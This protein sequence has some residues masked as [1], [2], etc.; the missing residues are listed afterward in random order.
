[1][2][3]VLEVRNME[4]VEEIVE[5]AVLFHKEFESKVDFDPDQIRNYGRY[6]IN[7]FDRD[8][9]NSFVGYSD[10]IPVGFLVCKISP[11][12][13]SKQ[14][15]ANQELWYVKP[16]FRGT[17][18]SFDLIRAMEDWAILRGVKEIFT[19]QLSNN[20]EKGKKISRVLSKIGYPR[21]G[22]YHRK[23]IGE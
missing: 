19:G 23:I 14:L 17:R 3:K 16:E 18:I 10:D 4:Q 21:A 11:Y 12:F 22:T 6:L 15:M 8:G 9:F 7:D 2:R 13:F 1:M 5:M 20:P